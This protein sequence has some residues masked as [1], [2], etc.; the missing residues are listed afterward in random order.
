VSLDTDYFAATPAELRSAFPKMAP[1]RSHQVMRSVVNP[2]TREV[3]APAL[4]T[5]YVP[6]LESYAPPKRDPRPSLWTRFCE[7]FM[8]RPVSGIHGLPHLSWKNVGPLELAALEHALRGTPM[9]AAIE[10]AFK[11]TLLSVERRRGDQI[12]ELDNELLRAIREID[13]DAIRTVAST[14]RT[15]CR[16][17]SESVPGWSDETLVDV[18]VQLRDLARDAMR[19]GRSVYLIWGA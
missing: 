13:D 5:E 3:L 18:V 14:W 8:P 2:F 11:P 19:D 9:D 10:A 6:D 4:R 15:A 1:V 12:T 16:D 17:L 7:Y